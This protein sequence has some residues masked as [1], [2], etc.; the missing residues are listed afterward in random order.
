MQSNLM[1]HL[2]WITALISIISVGMGLVFPISA[3]VFSLIYIRANRSSMTKTEHALAIF[4]LAAGIFF[5]FI[6][7]FTTYALISHLFL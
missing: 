1:L 2:S 4:S 6:G 3:L 5:T 7:L